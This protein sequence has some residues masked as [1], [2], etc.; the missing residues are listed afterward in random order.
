MHTSQ[1]VREVQLHI[2][3]NNPEL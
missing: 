3:T 1:K 2:K